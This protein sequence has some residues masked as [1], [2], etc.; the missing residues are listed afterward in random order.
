MTTWLPE[1]RSS[2]ADLEIVKRRDKA[3][4]F[5]KTEK[6]AKWLHKSVLPSDGEVGFTLGSEYVEDFIVSANNDEIEVDVL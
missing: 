6:G 1:G 5:P 2:M 4:V 3:Y